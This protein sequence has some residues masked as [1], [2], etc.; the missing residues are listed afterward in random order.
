M[1]LLKNLGLR[2]DLRLFWLYITICLVISCTVDRTPRKDTATKNRQTADTVS[3]SKQNTDMTDGGRHEGLDADSRQGFANGGDTKNSPVEL[4]GASPYS[5]APSND[6]STGRFTR[7]GAVVNPNTKTGLVCGNVTCAA[8]RADVDQCCTTRDDVTAKRAQQVGRCGVNLSA[9]G[10]PTCMQREQQ[11]TIYSGCPKATPKGATAEEVGCCS[12]EGKCATFDAMDGIG[13]HYNKGSGETCSFID[14]LINCERSGVF[15]LRVDIPVSWGGRS[16]GLIIDMMESGRGTIPVLL[17]ATINEINDKGEFTSKMKV[18]HAALPPFKSG[19]LCEAYQPVFPDSTWDNNRN[20]EV[21]VT[22]RY[23]CAN[24]GCFLTFDPLTAPIGVVLDDPDAPW[25]TAEEA[26]SFTCKAGKGE[27]C[28]PDVDN[29]GWPG[30]TVNMLTEGQSPPSQLCSGGYSNSAPPL[31]ESAGAIFDVVRRADRLQLGLRVRAGGSSLLN[32]ACDFE[33]GVAIASYVQSRA[34]GCMVQEGTY[35]L[36]SNFPAGPNTPC[37]A[38]ET[39]FINSNIPIYDILAA[40][41]I[42][43][44]TDLLDQSPSEGSRLKTVRLGKLGEAFSCEDVREA[45]LR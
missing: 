18:C 26:A 36:L 30:V 20:S 5:A 7:D 11:G 23:Q 25:P 1:S 39:A 33:P 43:P 40:G 27:A 22:G 13:C 3:G 37:S 12:A 17:L 14:A 16:G 9:R 21:S 31:L 44:Q 42:P 6:A 34:A 45:M 15:A 19:L 10:G 24:P 32:R 2:V 35:N 29:D 38:D 28:F 4:D 8:V 41:S